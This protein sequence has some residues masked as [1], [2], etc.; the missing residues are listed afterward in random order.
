MVSKQRE[1][2]RV[3]KRSHFEHREGSPPPD[4]RSPHAPRP[5]R[6]GARRLVPASARSLDRRR[7]RSVNMFGSPAPTTPAPGGGL[8]GAPAGACPL[9]PPPLFFPRICGSSRL[10]PSRSPLTALTRA[11][12]LALQLPAADSE[13]PPPLRVDSEP[14]RPRRLSG[15]HPARPRE[16]LVPPPPPPPRRRTR[17]VRARVHAG[18][19]RARG[20]RPTGGGLF[21]AAA[22][23]PPAAGGGLPA[24]APRPRQPSADYRR[25]HAGTS[26]GISARPRPRPPRRRAAVRRVGPRDA[27]GCPRRPRDGR[28][29]VW[30]VHLTGGRWFIGAAPRRR[31]LVRRVGPRDGRR[32]TAR[33]RPRRAVC[34]ARRP[35]T[36]GED[37]SALRPR[38]RRRSSAPTRHRGVCSARPGGE[39]AVPAGGLALSPPVPCCRRRTASP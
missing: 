28:R 34:S 22:R 30:R 18:V 29:F 26:G 3:C 27:G 38:P 6:R 31:R 17:R 25:V 7:D 32:R 12:L 19:Q 9:P 36:G 16:V 15:V 5:R 37:Y 8:F 10:L 23:R 1:N 24:A 4:L 11:F 14:P 33:P 2:T 21:G 35:A 13:P 39:R 20:Q